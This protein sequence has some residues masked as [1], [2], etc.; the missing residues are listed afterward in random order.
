MTTIIF[1]YK[2][3]TTTDVQL[4]RPGSTLGYAVINSS[5]DVGRAITVRKGRTRID[6]LAIDGA[7]QLLAG[8]LEWLRENEISATDVQSR[9]R[10]F[11][12]KNRNTTPQ[13][14]L[15]S[16]TVQNAI[17]GGIADAHNFRHRLDADKIKMIG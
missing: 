5:L 4:N 9:V 7:I 2:D 8:A 12:A 15:A 6:G 11:E 13:K 17:T 14:V 10:A 16:V 1:D 3:W